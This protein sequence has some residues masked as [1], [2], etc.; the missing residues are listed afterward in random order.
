MSSINF[1]SP[2]PPGT[3]L[4]SGNPI[5]GPSVELIVGHSG[6]D[7]SG[8]EMLIWKRNVVRAAG[9]RYVSAS[10]PEQNQRD[11]DQ[12]I[13]ACPRAVG[14]RPDG[15]VALPRLDPDS[16]D[17]PLQLLGNALQAVKRELGSQVLRG[18]A[19]AALFFLAGLGL[20]IV[21]IAYNV[22]HPQ[23]MV[24]FKFGVAGFVLLVS[25]CLIGGLALRLF[26]RQRRIERVLGDLMRRGEI[27]APLLA[28]VLAPPPVAPAAPPPAAPSAAAPLI[29]PV[30]GP[31]PSTIPVPFPPPA[32]ALPKVTL[33]PAALAILSL[34]MALCPFI[35]LV[36][37]GVALALTFRESSWVRTVAIVA[38]IINVLSSAF[39]VI[40]S[41]FA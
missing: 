38:L 21:I 3:I 5:P 9:K 32:A 31:S 2:H 36:L 34:C 12:W 28:Q 41:I 15:S 14:I 17:D 4:V 30:V 26:F 8:G 39:F 27:N 6:I 7:L 24:G 13:A 10:F 11:F 22:Q 19:L 29:P 20:I 37:A 40:M 35:G 23:G 33:V 25:A 18:F 1:V 16:P